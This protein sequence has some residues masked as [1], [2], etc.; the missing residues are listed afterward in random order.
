MLYFCSS[1]GALKTVK[2]R[3]DTILEDHALFYFSQRADNSGS[4][5]STKEADGVGKPSE[6]K[7]EIWKELPQGS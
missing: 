1:L 7:F 6:V 4:L 5:S 2:N 3:D